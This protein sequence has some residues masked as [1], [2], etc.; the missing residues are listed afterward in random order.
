MAG[1]CAY[2]PPVC[3]FIAYVEATRLGIWCAACLR[4]SAVQHLMLQRESSSR[5]CA[6]VVELKL[7]GMAQQP[8]VY[9]SDEALTAGWYRFDV[10]S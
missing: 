4:E 3:S 2:G 10:W 1:H 5:L 8:V 6:G 9:M 7:S